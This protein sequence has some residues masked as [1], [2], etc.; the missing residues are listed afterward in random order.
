MLDAHLQLQKQVHDLREKIDALRTTILQDRPEGEFALDDVFS[1]EEIVYQLDELCDQIK[2]YS[3]MHQQTN[4]RLLA[5]CDDRFIRLSN[6]L[7]SDWLSYSRVIPLVM[8]ANDHED[9]GQRWWDATQVGL[10]EVY[11]G[12]FKVRLAF[13]QCWLDLVTVGNRE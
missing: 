3:Q 6:R 5:D 1:D 8:Y 2:R 11:D 4:V 9:S 13:L 10:D 12:F 7:M